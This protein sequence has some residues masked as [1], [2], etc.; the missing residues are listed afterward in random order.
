MAVRSANSPLSCVKVLL[1]TVV[2]ATSFGGES[3]AADPPDWDFIKGFVSR[4]FRTQPGYEPGDLISRGHA[5]RV[6]EHLGKMGWKVPDR[7]AILRETVADNHVIVQQLGTKKGVKFMRKV[8]RDPLIFS[9][10][11]RISQKRGG[12]A[13]IRD[14]VRLPDGPKYASPTRIP[15]VPTLVELLPRVK[16]SKPQAVKDYNKPTGLIYT[17]KQLLAR[18]KKSYDKMAKTTA[19]LTQ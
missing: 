4:Y 17:E 2:L 7:S 1:L 9:K 15:G 13:L 16:R 8:T 12:A 3:V 19:N 5:T 14:V 11:D 10:L 18:L 6:I